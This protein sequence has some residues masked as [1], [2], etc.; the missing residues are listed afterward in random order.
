[1]NTKH[2]DNCYRNINGKRYENFCDLIYGDA[3][4]EKAIQEAREQFKS[5]RKIKHPSGYYQVFGTND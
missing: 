1:M 3:E 4:N 2:Q 5:V